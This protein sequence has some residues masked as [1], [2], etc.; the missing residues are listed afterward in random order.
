[1]IRAYCDLCMNSKLKKKCEKSLKLSTEVTNAQVYRLYI[2]IRF[3][4]KGLMKVTTEPL[5]VSF[6]YQTF[7]YETSNINQK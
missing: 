7:S 6:S 2:R 5:V 3:E 4:H 1:M